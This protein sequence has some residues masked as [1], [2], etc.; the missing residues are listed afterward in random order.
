MGLLLHPRPPSSRP[1]PGEAGGLGLGPSSMLGTDEVE[2]LRQSMGSWEDAREV[3]RCAG[4]QSSP[5]KDPVCPHQFQGLPHARCVTAGCLWPAPAR[6]P[7]QAGHRGTGEPRDLPN[8][9]SLRPQRPPRGLGV[10]SVPSSLGAG[11]CPVSP[12]AFLFS[13]LS[14]NDLTPPLSD[15]LSTSAIG[16]DFR[17]C[18]RNTGSDSLIHSFIHSL[19]PLCLTQS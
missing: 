15:A 18:P 16:P 9:S 14:T 2:L 11:G 19:P 6:R 1:N 13:P 7:R 10:P 12:C 4:A 3:F 17:T 8:L 5:C